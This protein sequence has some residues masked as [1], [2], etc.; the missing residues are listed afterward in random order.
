[1]PNIQAIAWQIEWFW[2]LALLTERSIEMIMGAKMSA[3]A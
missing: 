2:S 1:L 3:G